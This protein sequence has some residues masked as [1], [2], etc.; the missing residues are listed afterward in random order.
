MEHPL[1][2]ELLKHRNKEKAAF[3]PRFFRTGK[4]E[5][6]EGDVFIG[7]TIPHLRAIA[8]N[9]RTLSMREIEALLKDKRHEVRWCALFILVEQFKKGDEAAK[10]KIYEFY[11][12]HLKWVNNWDLVDSSAYHIVG[13]YLLDKDRKILRKMAKSKH[14]WTERVAM[15][16]TFAFIRKGQ[17]Q[18]TFEI[19]EMFL[20]HKHDLMHKAAGW[21]LREAG[22]RNEVALMR[23][24][25]ENAPVMPRTMLRYAIEKFD[26]KERKRYL[27]M[28]QL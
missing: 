10:K 13:E 6:G 8:K 9:Y 4:G 1:V 22:K 16:S 25:D 14:L 15:V 26:E 12:D 18:D 7:V 3:F 21:M 24:L 17:L 28:K 5:Y 23:F 27:L 2:K 19:A 20:S 11:L